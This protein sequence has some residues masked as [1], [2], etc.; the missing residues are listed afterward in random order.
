[1]VDTQHQ[2]PKSAFI[3]V[4]LLCN[5]RC[6]HC[7]IWKNRGLDFLPVSIYKK[8][9]TSLEMVDIT[10]GEPFLRNDIPEIVRIIR[11]R[12]PKARI[13]ITT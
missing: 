2:L 10:G 7:D 11:K 9:P 3:S 1:M 5:S 6:I 8:L 13:L 12:C 4:T